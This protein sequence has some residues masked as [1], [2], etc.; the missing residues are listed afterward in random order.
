MSDPRREKLV[1]AWLTLPTFNDDGYNLLLDRQRIHL[2]W[3]MDNGFKEGNA[4][5]MLAGGNGEGTMLN[6]D[7]WRSLANVLAEEAVGKVPTALGVYEFSA[8][9]AAKKAK[10]AAD[11]GIDFIQLAPPHYMAPSDNDVFGYYSYVND[12]SDVGIVAYNLPWCI[13]GA[14]E[15][16]QPLFERLATLENVVGI[17]WGCISIQHWAKMIRLFKHRFNFIEQGGILSVGFRLGI[18]GFTDTLGPVAPRLSLRKWELIREKRFEELDEIEIAKLDATVADS[19]LDLA[20][21]SG[22]GEGPTSR[23]P[24]RALGMETGPA[25]PYQDP[26]PDYWIQ[27]NQ[28]IADVTGLKE[29]VDWDQSIF[30]GLASETE[31]IFASAD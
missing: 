24:L 8:R 14:Y 27:N 12:A 3:L 10:Y 18:V 16:T 2:R 19:R 9:A 11:L 25:F 21:Y 26:L 13:P 30:D 17:K 28:R 22:M 1:G 5:L 23:E 29:W 6:E 20:T 31:T 4:V 15:F 7:E